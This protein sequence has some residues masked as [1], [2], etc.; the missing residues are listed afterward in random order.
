[1]RKCWLAVAS[2]EH[3][4]L[5][6]Q[7]GIMQVCHGRLAPLKRIQSND[8]VIYYSPTRIFRAKD[9]LQSFT[10]IGIVKAGE[11]YQVEMAD[12]FHPFRRDVDWAKALE[13]PIAPLLF[14]L[15]FTRNNKNW[16]Y[17][18]RFG[19]IPISDHD[20]SIIAN[21]MQAQWL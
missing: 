2:A 16:G 4:R 3:V 17:S 15:D 10:A 13:T 7:M 5:G 21:A 12:D 6:K 20:K 14:D 19:L 1:M 11:P 9:K 8:F 18:L